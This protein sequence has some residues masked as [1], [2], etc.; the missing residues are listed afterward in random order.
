MAYN[1][2]E[3]YLVGEEIIYQIDNEGLL[4]GFYTTKEWPGPVIEPEGE[5]EWEDISPLDDMLDLISSIK[6]T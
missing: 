6:T 2:L 1:N 5:M 4:Q 3:E